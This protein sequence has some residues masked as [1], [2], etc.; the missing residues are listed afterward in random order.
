MLDILLFKM[1][2][3]KSPDMLSSVPKNKRAIMCL[4][5]EMDVLDKLR[6]GAWII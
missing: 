6:S 3:V 4:V 2:S 5:E 1:A